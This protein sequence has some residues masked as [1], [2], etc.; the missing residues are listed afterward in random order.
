MPRIRGWGAAGSSPPAA[1]PA[2]SATLEGRRLQRPGGLRPCQKIG[3]TPSRI[4][5]YRACARAE[6]KGIHSIIQICSV[7]A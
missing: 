5:A 7:L 3:Q 6:V 2:W 1:A 4:W